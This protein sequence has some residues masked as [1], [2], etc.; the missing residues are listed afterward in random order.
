[1]K[2][3]SKNDTFSSLYPFVSHFSEIDS[4]GYRVHYIEEGKGE[5]VLFLHGFPS[6][7]FMYRD[8]ILELSSDFKCIALDHLGYGFSDK[9]LNYKYNVENHIKNAI[10]FAENMK[11]KKFHL[12]MHDF[13][14]AVGLAMA[15]RW[16]E[17]I[18]SMTF[19]NSSCFKHPK[20]P[21]SMM[22]MKLPI[23]STILTRYTNLL[24]KMFLHLGISSLSSNIEA[25]YLRPYDS[26]FNRVAISQGL[27]D[28]P[29]FPDHPSLDMYEKIESKAFILSNKKMKFFWS[30]L[31]F[32][33]TMASLK[34]W[35]KILPNAQLKRYE[36]GYYFLLEDCIEARNDVIAFLLK[37]HD[38]N[39]FLFK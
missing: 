32:L 37:N 19:F 4:R 36:Q 34:R 24:Q 15:E 38:I 20:L 5:T 27:M 13:G 29:I 18:S 2:L 28:I 6:W 7:S 17:R 9:P 10:K 31:D 26:I 35:A 39:K 33:H 16:P 21:F 12:V 30:N 25:G 1:M 11:F 22:L 8:L 23:I 14:V 3:L